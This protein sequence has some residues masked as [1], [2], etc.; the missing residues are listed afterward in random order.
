M[1]SFS[2]I[3]FVAQDCGHLPAPMN[4]TV[5]RGQTTYPNKLS[6]S[7]DEGFELVGSLVR[8][9]GADGNWTG[10]QPTCSGKVK[11]MTSL[12]LL[13]LYYRH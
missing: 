6:F 13:P 3:L 9:C 8:Q 2:A 7:C 12:V 5:T 4:G 10:H 11:K 1:L